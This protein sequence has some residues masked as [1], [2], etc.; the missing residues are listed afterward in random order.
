LSSLVRILS[1][2]NA[3]PRGKSPVVASEM[4]GSRGVLLLTSGAFSC[5]ISANWFCVS[6]A[7]ARRGAIKP[8]PTIGINKFFAALWANLWSVIALNFGLRYTFKGAV[9]TLFPYW[10]KWALTDGANSYGKR[11][12]AFLSLDSIRVPT[13]GGISRRFGLQSLVGKNLFYRISPGFAR[14]EMV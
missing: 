7:V 3:T 13:D 14:L 10:L 1:K 12:S 5:F 2:T 8:L 6:R 4:F 11:H 9:N